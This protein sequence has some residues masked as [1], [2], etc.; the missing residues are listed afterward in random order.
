MS[1]AY[2]LKRLALIGYTL[3]VVSLIVFGITQILPADA[4]VMLLGENATPAALV[5]VRE[6]LGL[7]APAWL[8]YVHWLGDVLQGDF[9][10]SMRTGQP[11]GPALFQALGRSLQ[12]ALCAI[13]LTLAIALP[14]GI[15]G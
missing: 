15:I 10:T 14:L 11:V 12:L 1:L 13:L 2:F 9:G 6:K 5:A 7:D 4:A 3:F 8:Q